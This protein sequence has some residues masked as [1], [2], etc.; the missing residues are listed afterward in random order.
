MSKAVPSFP[1]VTVYKREESNKGPASLTEVEPEILSASLLQWN[2]P[3][4][5]KAGGGIV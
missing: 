2:S 3:E 4:F 1:L 5:H